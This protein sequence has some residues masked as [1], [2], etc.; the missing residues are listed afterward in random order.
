[1]HDTVLNCH[2]GVIQHESKGQRKLSTQGH[3]SDDQ[4]RD[5]PIATSTS[6]IQHQQ[7]TY[8][9]M[10]MLHERRLCSLIYQQCAADHLRS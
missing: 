5:R 1:M 8:Y 6:D 4:E 3:K 7:N 9:T 10:L 2:P